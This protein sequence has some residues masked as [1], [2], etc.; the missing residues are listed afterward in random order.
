M[1]E[2]RSTWRADS[3]TNSISTTRQATRTLTLVAQSPVPDPSSGGRSDGS[4]HGVG[5]GIALIFMTPVVLVLGV[6]IAYAGAVKCGNTA[7]GQTCQGY[8]GWG[9]GAA[10]VLPAA[11][12][13]ICLVAHRRWSAAPLLCWAI[14]IVGVPLLIFIK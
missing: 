8:S 3:C 7:P 5:A 4:G 9:F 13:I 12:G 14:A 1:V 2:A 11:L 6:F 10:V